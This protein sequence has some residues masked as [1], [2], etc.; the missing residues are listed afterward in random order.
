[1]KK[2]LL[3]AAALIALLVPA[4]A[5]DGPCI[6]ADPTGTPLNVRSSP[7]GRIIGALHN[8]E[9]VVIVGNAQANGKK[10]APC[11]P[12]IRQNWLGVCRLRDV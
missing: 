2:L 3:T 9:Q 4:Y 10:V 5:G 12:G 7:N 6:A 11:H 8:D 1:M